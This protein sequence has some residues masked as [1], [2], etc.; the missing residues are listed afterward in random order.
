LIRLPFKIS[1]IQPAPQGPLD[2]AFIHAM[3]TIVQLDQ[4]HGAVTVLDPHDYGF[5][6]IGG[7]P[8]D[9]LKDPAAA[10]AYIDVMRRIAAVFAH[11]DVAIGLMNEPHTGSDLAY[12][13][14]WNQAIAAIRAAGFRGTILV[15]HAH[16]SNAADI[17]PAH[18]FTGDIADPLHNWV[19]E[20]H[21]Y[22]DPDSTGTYRQPV[23]NADIG[24][25]RLSGAIA[26]S[27]GSGIKLFLG[28][29]GAPPDAVG[30]SALRGVLRAVATAPDVFWGIALWG[31]GPW[32][33]PNYPM[34][35]DPIDG[36]PRPQF[37]TLQHTFV[38]ELLYFAKP[39]GQEAARVAVFV[40]GRAVDTDL[41]I[42]ADVT[43]SPQSYPIAAELPPGAHRIDIRPLAPT[44]D[45][46]AYVLASTWRGVSDSQDAFGA[47]EGRDYSFAITI[48]AAGAP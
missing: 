12:S 35:L 36:A 17:S 27:R 20:L 14:L 1:R 47:I 26:W 43:G 24:R 8:A 22:L 42:T 34:R 23:V 44:R 48:P 10:A 5:Y 33:K 38:P 21:L 6:D 11:D 41:G 37:V 2:P 7:K 18:P 3:K 19:L 28:E 30:V 39:A 9:L 46:T 25:E 4:A 32:W 13:S 31:A 40:D 45:L 15:P 16:W 29:T